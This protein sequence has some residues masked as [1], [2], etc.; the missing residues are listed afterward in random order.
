[1]LGS[2]AN[3]VSRHRV[4]GVLWIATLPLCSRDRAIVLPALISAYLNQRLFRYDALANMLS[5]TNT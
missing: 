2:M 1:M 4:F 5:G 3:R